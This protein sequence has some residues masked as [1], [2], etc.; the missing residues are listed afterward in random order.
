MLVKLTSEQVSKNW[1]AIRKAIEASLPPI[2]V[3]AEDRMNRIL[4]A[5][6]N[7]YAHC[8]FNYNKDDQLDVVVVTSFLSDEITGIKNLFIFAMYGMMAERR[9]WL[10]GLKTLVRFARGHGCDQ[11]VAYS[12]IDSVIKFVER[13]GGDGDFR[14]IRIPVKE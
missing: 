3:G 9:S 7:D 14:L 12:D 5:I 4:E 6:I 2:S 13:V 1:P 8:W 11:I 10:E